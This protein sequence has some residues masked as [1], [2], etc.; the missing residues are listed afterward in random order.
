MLFEIKSLN[1]RFVMLSTVEDAL[2]SLKSTQGSNEQM[3]VVIEHGLV[4]D[5]IAETLD[6]LADFGLRVELLK[7]GF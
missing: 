5:G 3:L 2:S 1:V 4:V 7:K 6:L